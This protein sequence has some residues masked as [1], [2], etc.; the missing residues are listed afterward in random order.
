MKP[1]NLPGWHYEV[2]DLTFGRNRIV[3]TDGMSV[4]DF[5]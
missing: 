4:T 1:K 3:Y 5:W 2:W